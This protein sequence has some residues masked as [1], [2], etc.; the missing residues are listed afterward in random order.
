[1]KAY[2]LLLPLLATLTLLSCSDDPTAPAAAQGPILPLAVGNKWAGEIR[3]FNPDGTLVSTRHELIGIMG[4]TVLSGETWY[5]VNDVSLL[6]NRA[7]GLY[8]WHGSSLPDAP[9]LVLKHPATVGQ[10]SRIQSGLGM[11]T[12]TL[13]AIGE[14]VTVGEKA[15]VAPTIV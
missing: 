15:I 14:P 3:K 2:R 11:G 10:S 7:D 1:M 4:D 8:E 6:T 12:V 5:S 9:V 13:V